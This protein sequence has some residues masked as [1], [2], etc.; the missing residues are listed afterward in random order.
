MDVS[1]AGGGKNWK[2]PGLEFAG[3]LDGRP[4]G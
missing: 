1:R 4:A 2:L 3:L